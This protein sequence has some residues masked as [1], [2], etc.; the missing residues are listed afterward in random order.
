M[1]D[2]MVWLRMGTQVPNFKERQQVADEIIKLRKCVRHWVQYA[3]EKDI[4]LVYGEPS[5][6]VS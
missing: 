3:I 6:D 5:D 2:I 1:N 4:P